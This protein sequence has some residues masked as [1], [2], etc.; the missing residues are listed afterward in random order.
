MRNHRF[1][2]TMYEGIN[3]SA[4]DL[5][6]NPDKRKKMVNYLAEC[7]KKLQSEKDQ[8]ETDLRTTFC[9]DFLK[10][11]YPDKNVNLAG[12]IDLAIYSTNSPKSNVKV[13]FEYKKPSNN[14]EMMHPDRD[15]LNVKGFRELIQYYLYQRNI[16]HDTDITNGIVTDGFSWFIIDSDQLYKWFGKYK[17]L[18]RNYIKFC[19]GEK[20]SSRSEYFR[21]YFI[22]KAI[23]RALKHN[24]KISYFDL[25]RMVKSEDSMIIKKKYQNSLY[26]FFSRQNL[27]KENM[28]NDT[29]ELN[30]N[31]YN[32]LL[33]I[34]GLHEVKKNKK[35]IL[36]RYSKNRQPGS[37]IENIITRLND[38]NININKDSK[39][40]IAIRLTVLWINRL[41]FLKLL[42]SQLL[43]FND[44]NQ[45]YKFLTKANL[46]QFSDVYYLFFD[47]LSKTSK[48][49]EQD[50]PELANKYR[51]VPY[52][53]SSLFMKSNLEKN[54]LNIIYLH[55]TPIDPYKNT[56]IKDI[57]GKKLSKPIPI[58]QY[59][60][61]F[62]DSYDFRG[63][64]SKKHSYG[65]NL[66]NPSVLG[67]I[68]EKINGYK[69]G[70]YFTPGWICN[71]MA[72]KAVH[73]TIL[74]KI[75]KVKNWH[76]NTIKDLR[77][78]IYNSDNISIPMNI[79][80]II[81][82]IKVCDPSVGSGHFLVSVLNELLATKSY[83]GVLFYA[84]KSKDPA[85][86]KC[87]VENDELVIT[88]H[89]KPYHYNR[90]DSI[91]GLIQKTLFQEKRK[92]I[93][94]CLFGVDINPNSVDICRL[95][96]WIELLKNAYYYRS[97][98]DNKIH[99]ITMPNIDI[100]VKARNSLIYIY[101]L[102]HGL[103]LSTKGIK[104]YKSYVYDYKRSKDKSSEQD[105]INEIQKIKTDIND[106]NIFLPHIQ[107]YYRK[108]LRAREK[109]NKDE[110]PSLFNNRSS[111]KS[112]RK[113]KHDIKNLQKCKKIFNDV[114]NGKFFKDNHG[115]EWRI[116][117]PEI[118]DN[119]GNYKGFD[120][121]IG[122][123]PYVFVR[124][125][126]PN[127]DQKSYYLNKY[128]IT[129]KKSK[130]N[131]ALISDTYCMFIILA[132]RLLKKNG[133]FA[134]IIPSNLLTIM[135]L[136]TLRQFLIKNTN[137]LNIINS[138]DNL[139][140]GANVDNCLIFFDKRQSNR[141]SK[142][143]MEYMKHHDC[144]PVGKTGK[145]PY[146]YFNPNKA[147]D[148]YD[149]IFSLS[150]VKHQDLIDV[151]NKMS[152]CPTLGQYTQVI[153]GAKAYTTGYGTPK[154][155]KADGKNRIYHHAHNNSKH[156]YDKY[157]GSNDVHRY[158]ITWGLTN[159]NEKW[160]QYGKNLAQPGKPQ[161]FQTP[162]ILVDQ[163]P[164]NIPYSV[165]ASYIKE[166]NVINDFNSM[167]IRKCKEPLNLLCILGIINSNIETVWFSMK[168]DKFQRGIYPQFKVGELADFPIP[169]FQ[170]KYQ[171]NK[172]KDLSK[173]MI[174][175]VKNK[176]PNQ[177][178][179][180]KV[181]DNYVMKLY[182]LNPI[183]RD[184]VNHFNIN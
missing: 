70:A 44:N 145:V 87:R 119:N 6:P 41:L 106:S 97:H 15:H 176:N 168:F 165:K 56:S 53:N 71:L 78:K 96:L 8:R 29:N 61:D 81:N 1:L 63:T 134:Y 60:L 128:S 153:A 73:N 38:K 40:K 91:N 21:T 50:D 180:N 167:I 146:T 104:K 19:K 75:N 122:N 130:Y 69:Y 52:L 17:T 143:K 86:F 49:R 22:K 23:N 64:S 88:Y 109:V 152:K 13:I 94:D 166:P 138:K 160:I 175:L 172:L 72:K 154:Q 156:S 9:N 137:N 181:I 20:E 110:E 79:N 10:K 149:P 28:F 67:L 42:E 107:K 111:I 37:F 45:Q 74:N 140:K 2:Q 135:S 95:R 144:Y 84:N 25:R 82:T 118:L 55:N 121:I 114:K 35:I 139:F 65:N 169:I 54:Y 32:E 68:F 108:Y 90:Y 98:K 43:S 39:N 151:Y 177:Y 18:N 127:K 159:P 16:K 12:N 57:H 59:L 14:K 158:N 101:N 126:K 150:R 170:N 24:I 184:K 105:L 147:M 62:L 133:S 34:M 129:N 85:D 123:P 66:I 36:K 33:Y 174:K 46:H 83:L 148:K 31:F 117:F 11:I 103:S 58:L 136:K 48:Q 142:I 5:I 183:E 113:L 27:L 77:Y 125:N 162:R 112:T 182:Q 120:L 7:L 99:L 141:K 51:R 179:I 163:I 116:E 178:R 80:H 76:C 89:G 93:E 164:G 100:N 157:L 155:T 173:E 92:L 132:Y 3:S 102:R 124:G 26:K 47:I 115:M 131:T 30:K 4:K 171:I 161:Y